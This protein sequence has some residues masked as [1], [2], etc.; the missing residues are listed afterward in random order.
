MHERG[1]EVL[2]AGNTCSDVAMEISEIHE[3]DQLLKYSSV[4]YGHSSACPAITTEARLVLNSVKTAIPGMVVSMQ[5]MITIPNRLP[6]SGGYREH[7]ILVISEN[8]NRNIAHHP[9]GPEKMIIRK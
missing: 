8:G 6:G 3:T 9:Y 5:Q 4:G 7:D 1:I 2:K